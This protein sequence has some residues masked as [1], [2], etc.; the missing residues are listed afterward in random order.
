LLHGFSVKNHDR[1]ADTERTAESR[2]RCGLQSLI[3][4]Q[5]LPVDTAL[6]GDF[7]VEYVI[8]RRALDPIGEVPP[9]RRMGRLRHPEKK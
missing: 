7:E 4:M 3:T 2:S 8:P 6:G 5:F 1:R 9:D